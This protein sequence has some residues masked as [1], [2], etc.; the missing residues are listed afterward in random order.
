[1]A[2]IT[3][4]EPSLNFHNQEQIIKDKNSENI[5]YF[6]KVISPNDEELK[7][8]NDYLKNNLKNNFF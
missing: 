3:Q 4:G 7:K 1:M 5:S 2:L 8:H 6:K